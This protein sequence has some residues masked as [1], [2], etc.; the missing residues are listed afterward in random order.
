MSTRDIQKPDKSDLSL[1]D[2]QMVWIPPGYELAPEPAAG[3]HRSHLW[4]YIWVAWRR[5]WLVALVFAFCTGLALLVTLRAQPIYEGLAK[6]RI[7]PDVPKILSFDNAAGGQVL[8]YRTDLPR[9]SA[10]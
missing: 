6:L 9:R 10:R 5:R 2:G 4:D 3:Q 7:E 8:D 1:T